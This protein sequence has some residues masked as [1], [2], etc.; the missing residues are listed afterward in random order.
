MSVPQSSPNKIYQA[1]FTT[2]AVTPLTPE[3]ITE[4][5]QKM[6]DIHEWARD[7][8]EVRLQNDPDMRQYN[9]TVEMKQ[10]LP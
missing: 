7:R 4:Y 9:C 3:E 6:A 5:T 2:N 8:I 1:Q 10:Q